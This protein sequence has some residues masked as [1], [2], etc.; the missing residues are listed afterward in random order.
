MEIENLLKIRNI[1]TTSEGS[2]ILGYLLEVATDLSMK[3]FDEKELKGFLRAVG[4]LKKI[5]SKVESI[6]NQK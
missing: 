6:R 4:E 3:D 5:P 2:L 1:L